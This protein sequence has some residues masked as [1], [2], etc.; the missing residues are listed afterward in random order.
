MGV[1]KFP[2]LDT[3]SPE[4]ATTVVVPEEGFTVVVMGDSIARGVIYD[5]E[6]KTYG[7]LLENFTNIVREKMK[8][9]VYNAAK[10][11]STIVEG[12]DRVQQDVLRR[13]PDIV[14]IEFGGND[15]D[16][17]WD[18]IAEDPSKQF[19]PRTDCATFSEKLM[20]LVEHLT[21]MN[22]I[23]VL[24]SLP[25]LDPAKY[26][27]W[28]SRNEESA[29]QN[30]IRF[31]GDLSQIYSWHERYNAAILR[32]AEQTKTRLIDIRSAFLVNENYTQLI[33]RDGIHPNKGGHRVIAEKILDY[34]RSD[35]PF[36]LAQ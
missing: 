2:L 36:L 35:Y 31:I 12:I 10:Y 9:A 8:G 33:C 23:P 15:C 13:K 21:S 26:F 24:V 6:K 28:I 17:H 29:K 27:E 1:G 16:F 25:P 7:L 30:I 5:E 14:L 20:A 34:I 4:S 3:T 22:I 19:Q 18:A 32:V 11:G